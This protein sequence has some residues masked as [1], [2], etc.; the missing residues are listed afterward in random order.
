MRILIMLTMLFILAVGLFGAA[1]FNN[2]DNGTVSD[3]G[4]GLVW[5]KCSMG[6]NTSDCSGTA[7]YPN[8]QGALQYCLNL[9]L[10][11]KSWR[12]PSVNELKSIV[13]YSTC[14]PAINSAFFPNTQKAHYWSS[15][16]YV[17][18]EDTAWIVNFVYGHVGNYDKT[19][20]AFVRCVSDGP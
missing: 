16:T 19:S 11:G 7:A 5:Q 1:R 17:Y 3:N 13:D 8:W 6:Q 2:N 9:P 4:T 12:L 14:D 15:S 10:A 20:I 18:D